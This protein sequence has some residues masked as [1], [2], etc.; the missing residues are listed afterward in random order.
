MTTFVLATANRHKAEEMRAV[1]SPL[2]VDLLERPPDAADVEENGATL[3]ANALLKARALVA[4]TGQAAIADDTGLFVDA[5][6]G[7][8]GVRSARYAG[9]GASYD[10]N[11]TKLLDELKGAIEPR[12]ARFVTVIAVAYPDGTTLCVEGELDGVITHERAGDQ[13]F[14]YDPVFAPLGAAGRTL[15]QLAPREKNELSHRGRALRALG[16]ELARE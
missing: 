13:G 9:E 6:D 2:G 4:A 1:L 16:E 3:E 7:R 12:T 11:V 14:G 10:D 5:L 8:P 15:A